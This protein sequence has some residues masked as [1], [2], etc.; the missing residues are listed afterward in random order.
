VSGAWIRPAVVTPPLTLAA[1]GF[2]HPHEL[3]AESANWWTVL[4]IVLLPIFPLLGVAHWLLVRSADGFLAGAVRVL[5]FAYVV[6]Y[7]ALD[8]IAGIATGTLMRHGAPEQLASLSGI[9]N[10]LGAIGAGA[11][12]IASVLT[13]VIAHRRFGRRALLGA[14]VLAAASVVFLQSHI[15]W[16]AGVL[17][18]LGI[19][20]GFGLLASGEQ[21]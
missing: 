21:G 1:L 16:P 5:A 10:A 11:F 18:M 2:T 14:L 3:T 12:L 17:A 19:A 7:G 8:A 15:Y 6:F 9:G 13:G 20:V 4:H